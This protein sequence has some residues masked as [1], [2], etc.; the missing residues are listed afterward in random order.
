MPNKWLSLR[1]HPLKRQDRILIMKTT[2]LALAIAILAC[3]SYAPADALSLAQEEAQTSD[4]TLPA[5]AKEESPWFFHAAGGGNMLFDANYKNSNLEMKFGAGV[6][7]DVGVG[8]SLNKIFAVQLQ[9]GFAWNKIKSIEG[10]PFISGGEGNAYQ[11]PLT[12][13][14]VMGFPITE[15]WN[16]GFSAGGGI[17]WANLKGSLVSGGQSVNYDGTSYA[18]RYQLGVAATRQIAHNMTLGFGVRFSGTTSVDV[19]ASDDKLKG[20]TNLGL[21]ATFKLTF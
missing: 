7:V 4:S 20:L 19:G 21:G 2:S 6:A 14:L 3:A 9:T 8:Y 15:T 12:V 1:I 18:F 11:I 10:S 16:L 13:N 17:E 5:E